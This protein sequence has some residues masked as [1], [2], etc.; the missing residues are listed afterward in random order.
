[1]RSDASGVTALLRLRSSPGLSL[2]LIPLLP[3]MAAVVARCLHVARG[4]LRT[5]V[6]RERVTC[7]NAVVRLWHPLLLRVAL[8]VS[9]A[10]PSS[11]QLRRA[12]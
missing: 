9:R 11:S 5:A 12:L 4:H 7:D 8:Y 3:F 1:M 6:Q 10:E 2:S